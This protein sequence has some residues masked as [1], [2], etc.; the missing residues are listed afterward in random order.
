MYRSARRPRPSRCSSEPAVGSGGHGP[1]QRDV[2]GLRHLMT[3]PGDV[4]GAA[5]PVLTASR[6]AE[7]RRA[8]WSVEDEHW[9]TSDDHRHTRE[10]DAPFADPAM[11]PEV[12]DSNGTR[13]RVAHIGHGGVM[14]TRWKL[15][16]VERF[17]QRRQSQVVGGPGE[18]GTAGGEQAGRGP[19]AAGRG[20]RGPG[21]GRPPATTSRE[22]PRRAFATSTASAIA[23]DTPKR[24]SFGMP[25]ADS[26]WARAW[27]WRTTRGNGF[28][29]K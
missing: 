27:I 14:G 6:F 16:P 8:R 9:C 15:D 23:H 19:A 5:G 28:R 26:F 22:P 3:P 12:A 7:A 20:P 11:A 2:A 24:I 29:L 25:C 18:G 21:G 1:I 13:P 17:V 4:V 10:R